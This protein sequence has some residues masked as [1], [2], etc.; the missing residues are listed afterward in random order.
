M[1]PCSTCGEHKELSEFHKNNCTVD[2]LHTIC[3][4]C[5]R[6]WAKAYFKTYRYLNEKARRK[7]K[8]K[9]NRDKLKLL[10]KQKGA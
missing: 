6:E 8:T 10:A 9:W 4:V 1:K 5:R 3:K 2:G 7:Y